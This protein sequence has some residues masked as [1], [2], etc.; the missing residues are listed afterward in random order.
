MRPPR[1]PQL[2]S[3]VSSLRSR[4]SSTVIDRGEARYIAFLEDYAFLIGGLL[5]LYE[6]S[7]D[8]KYIDEAQRLATEMIRQ[9]WDAEN[10]AF[11]QSGA[12]HETLIV[13]T[14]DFY[15]GAIP[16]GN[17]V[18]THGLLRLATYTQDSLIKERSDVMAR[19]GAALFDQRPESH[20]QLLMASAMDILPR[21]DVVFVGAP[22]GVRPFVKEV[23]RRYLP[24]KTVVHVDTTEA[25]ARVAA[26]FGWI[27]QLKIEIQKD[28]Y[29]LARRGDG[30]F[31][32]FDSS[33]AL[34]KFLDG[35]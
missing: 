8:L 14:K 3:A 13:R 30:E 21:V 22:G 26:K 10:S 18:A 31:T 4:N 11:F 19:V 12:E 7:L 17:A 6:S 24:A 33:E 35:A 27:K 9:F 28:G 5:D 1:K 20:P 2:S 32:K 34:A 16:S 29:C 23:H 15:D 25:V